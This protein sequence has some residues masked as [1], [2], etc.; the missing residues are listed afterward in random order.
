LVANVQKKNTFSLEVLNFFRIQMY[1]QASIEMQQKLADLMKEKDELEEC[2]ERSEE[3]LKASTERIEKLK[4]KLATGGK[5]S[6]QV[7]QLKNENMVQKFTSDVL[8]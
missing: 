8:I 1:N 7:A 4:D 2:L 6:Q 3:N 5:L